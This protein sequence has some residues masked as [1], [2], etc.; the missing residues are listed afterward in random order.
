VPRITRGLADGE[1]YHIINRGNR[2]SEV[3]H[4]E[5]DYK[6]FIS[7]LKEAKKINNIKIYS[8]TL[9]PNHFHLVLKPKKAEDLS[10]FMQWLMTSYVRFYNKTYKTSGH[11]WQGRDKSF[12]VQKNN[13]LLTLLNYVEQNPQRAKLKDWKYASRQ[14]KDSFLIDKLPIEIPDDWDDFL[15]VMEK[16]KI[17]NSIKRQSP[18]GEDEWQ[19][20]ICERHDIVSTIRPRGR[21]KNKKEN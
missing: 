21:P 8:F 20:N 5:E 14:Y 15:S 11:L 19:Q 18:Y 13:Y 10:K 12:F 3:F 16:E 4:K 7:L 1:I 2:R 17:E 9:M 6:K